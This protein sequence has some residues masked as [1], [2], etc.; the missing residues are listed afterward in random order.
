MAQWCCKIW[1]QNSETI[2][3]KTPCSSLGFRQYQWGGGRSSQVMLENPGMWRCDRNG[4]P[5]GG[6]YPHPQVCYNNT[7]VS[8]EYLKYVQQCRTHGIEEIMI[9]EPSFQTCFCQHCCAYFEQEFGGDL[10]NMSPEDDKYKAFQKKTVLKFLSTIM[11]GIKAIDSSL[12]TNVCVMPCDRQLFA[13]TA[14]IENLDVLGVDPYWLRPVN[15]LT[16]ED[17]V[18]VSKEAKKQAKL[19]NKRFELY[20]GCFG[21]RGGCGL[22]EKIYQQGKELVREVGPDILTTWSY[23]GG[24]GLAG[25]EEC[26]NPELAWASV[27]RLYSEL[28]HKPGRR[29]IEVPHT[30]SKSSKQ[31]ALSK[32]I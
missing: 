1:S 13:E 3:F 32:S 6:C 18:N 22:E 20:L 19:N 11:T 10:R 24:L 2:W 31:I 27:V 28:S 5:F 7:D 17:A 8:G 21:I 4:K 23:K 12:A 30:I 9:D 29:V 26:D 15:N 16:F 25:E 14:R